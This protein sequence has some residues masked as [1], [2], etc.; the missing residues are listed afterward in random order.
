VGDEALREFEGAILVGEADQGL[1]DFHGGQA[2]WVEK[3]VAG[4]GSGNQLV[5]EQLL[6]QRVAIDAEDL[7][8]QASGCRRPA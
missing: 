5:V 8:G 6:A 7:G 3:V 1:T 4:V 2:Q